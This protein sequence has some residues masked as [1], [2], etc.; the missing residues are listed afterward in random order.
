MVHPGRAIRTV[1]T[2]HGHVLVQGVVAAAVAVHAPNGDAA[3]ARR[4]G[5]ERRVGFGEGLGDASG[6][7]LEHLF[8]EHANV[9]VAGGVAA[10]QGKP[11][12]AGM[13]MAGRGQGPVDGQ[14][15]NGRPGQ[16][17]F[18]GAQGYAAGID[19]DQGGFHS[20]VVE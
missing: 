7:K 5:L 4:H 11:F 13:G 20:V 16:G 17:R 18:D 14:P 8:R 12:Q 15:L 6:H 10:V 2:Q 19:G 3:R 1:E 9:G